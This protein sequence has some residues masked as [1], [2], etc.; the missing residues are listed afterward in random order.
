MPACAP[1]A[2]LLPST[3]KTI[4]VQSSATVQ[5]LVYVIYIG[6]NQAATALVDAASADLNQIDNLINNVAAATGGVVTIAQNITSSDVSGDASPQN[7]QQDAT[8]SLLRSG[9]DNL[10]T[11]VSFALV[12][13][14]NGPIGT[15]KA[16]VALTGGW[17][18]GTYFSLLQSLFGMWLALQ[19]AQPLFDSCCV[20]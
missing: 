7:P 10:Q 9:G 6:G 16:N 20:P 8:L 2:A 13:S 15:D 1:A 4:A 12:A 3:H 17:R 18:E 5:Y 14:Y 19:C 11:G